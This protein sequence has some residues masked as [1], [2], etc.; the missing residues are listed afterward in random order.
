MSKRTIAEMM[1]LPGSAYVRPE[2]EE[3]AD[4]FEYTVT[5]LKKGRKISLEFIAGK[6]AAA[7][8]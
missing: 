1:N 3:T 7:L 8:Y 4:D 2:T 5:P 6:E